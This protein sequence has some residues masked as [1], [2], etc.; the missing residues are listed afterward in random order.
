MGKSIYFCII[1]AIIILTNYFH[2]IF[3]PLENIGNISTIRKPNAKL[4]YGQKE[5]TMGKINNQDLAMMWGDE[6]ILHKM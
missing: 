6:I 4:Y 5:Y 3:L 1:S 2:D